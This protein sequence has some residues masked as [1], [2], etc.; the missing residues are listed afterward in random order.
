MRR[1]HSEQIGH[2]LQSNSHSIARNGRSLAGMRPNARSH[3][4]RLA[5]RFPNPSGRPFRRPASRL[6]DLGIRRSEHRSPAGRARPGSPPGARPMVDTARHGVP[7]G[8]GPG[9]APGRIGQLERMAEDVVDPSRAT[10]ASNRSRPCSGRWASVSCSAGGSSHGEH[11]G[12][13]R[14]DEFVSRCPLSG[15]TV[16]LAF[17]VMFRRPTDA[18]LRP[19]RRLGRTAPRHCAS[20]EAEGLPHME[21]F[22]N[23]RYQEVVDPRPAHPPERDQAR[24]ADDRRRRER[25]RTPTRPR[26]SP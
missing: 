3:A 5:V 11:P 7:V 23:R 26:T 19:S 18:G 24:D 22:A 17:A 4:R 1:S 13:G 15:P 16:R 21:I 2:T 25:E 20:T 12:R 6:L 10:P 14:R 9:G 8:D